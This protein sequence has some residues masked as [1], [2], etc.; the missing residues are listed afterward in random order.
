M[1]CDIHPYVEYFKD[2]KW[3]PAE[4]WVLD[5]KYGDGEK[6]WRVPSHLQVSNDRNYH[7]FS[8]LADVR[9]GTWG[10]V[11][12]VLAEP[13]GLPDDV[14]ER[15]KD[16]SNRWDCDGHSHS[17]F[18]LEELRDGWN[19][20]HDKGVT[21]HG[22]IDPR[23]PSP[24]LAEWLAKDPTKRGEPPCGYCA[25]GTHCVPF[26]WHQKVKDIIGETYRVVNGYLW[27]V[28]FEFGV[29]ESEVRFVFWFDN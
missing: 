8:W 15:I 16:S 3:N 6:T 21:F 11:M 18:T 28:R 5:D 20:D 25:M 29:N 27:N 17:Y 24:E 4:P 1:G 13:R 23:N 10:E 14:N 2:G 19:R 9:N 22:A 7:W 26:E 12:P